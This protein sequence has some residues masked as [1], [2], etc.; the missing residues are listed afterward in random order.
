M[1]YAKITVVTIIAMLLFSSASASE[2]YTGG[3]WVKT[4]HPDPHNISIFYVDHQAIKAIGY[5]RIAGKPAIWYAE[6]SFRNGHLILRYRYSPHATPH[7]WEAEGIMQL[8]LSRDGASLSGRA[9]SLSGA[10]SDR[11]EFRRINSGMARNQS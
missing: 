5:G 10:W 2:G 4:N 7:G 3:A 6:G 1:N 8:K 9:R 11:V